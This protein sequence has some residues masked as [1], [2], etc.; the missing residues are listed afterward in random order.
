MLDLRDV[1]NEKPSKEDIISATEETGTPRL[2]TSAT[3][4]TTFGDIH[5][6][7]YAKVLDQIC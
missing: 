2:Y 5:V 6:E 7:L 1:F 4:H 3:I